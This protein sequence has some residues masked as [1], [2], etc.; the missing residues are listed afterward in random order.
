M[1][2]SPSTLW[3]L[4]GESVAIIV[5]AA[6]GFEVRLTPHAALAL[7]GAPCADLNCAVVDRG[8]DPESSLRELMGRVHARDVPVMVFLT[9]DVAEALAPVAAEL[10]LELGGRAPLMLRGAQAPAL[11]SGRFDVQRVESAT[12][13]D[14]AVAVAAAA[15]SLPP[16]A[17]AGT[18]PPDVLAGPGFDYFLARDDHDSPVSSCATTRHGNIVGVWIMAT[19]PDHQR[20]GAGRALL[21]YTLTYHLDRN[22][23]HFYLGATE[24]GRPLYERMGFRAIASAAIWVRGHSTQAMARD[25]DG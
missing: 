2:P 16:D 6:P 11:G 24:A 7:S 14:D 22:V 12:D 20:Q 19:A 8:P 1:E 25:D 4:V 23:E 15:F 18:M 21:E 10:G 17:V 5:R 13:L 3:R 9:D